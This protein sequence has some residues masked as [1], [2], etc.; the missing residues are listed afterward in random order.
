MSEFTFENDMME[1]QGEAV[2]WKHTLINYAI[3]KT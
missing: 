1:I 3:K 2:N